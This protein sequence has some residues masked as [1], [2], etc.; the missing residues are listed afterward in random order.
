MAL[1]KNLSFCIGY[2]N[3]RWDGRDM[4][5]VGDRGGV[6]SGVWW[7]GLKGRVHMI[8][9]RLDEIR[10]LKVIIKK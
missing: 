2:L 5:H 3:E 9:R 6:H 10:R 1:L 8:N 7:G 4:W